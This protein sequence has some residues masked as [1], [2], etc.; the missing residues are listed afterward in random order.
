MKWLDYQ[1]PTNFGKAVAYPVAQTDFPNLSS[2]GLSGT[3]PQLNCNFRLAD[4]PLRVG[5]LRS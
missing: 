3:Y 5:A 2:H 1:F 4:Y